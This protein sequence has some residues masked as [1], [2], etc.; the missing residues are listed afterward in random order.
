MN[1]ETTFVDATEPSNV[2]NAIRSS[3]K[4]VWLESPTNPLLK[5]I[6]IKRIAEIAHNR[7]IL[8]AVDNT[9]LTPYFQVMFVFKNIIFA[10]SICSI[11]S[12]L[13]YM[14]K[15]HNCYLFFSL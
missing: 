15:I 2:E 11:H 5:V 1:V 4:L 10:F 6:D 7:N 8:L 13:N 14:F 12:E 3:T 9:F